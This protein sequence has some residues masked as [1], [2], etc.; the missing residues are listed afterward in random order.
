M[1]CPECGVGDLHVKYAESTEPHGER[2]LDEWWECDH[3]QW[4]FSEEDLKGAYHRP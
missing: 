3:C 4:K 1:I 2:C